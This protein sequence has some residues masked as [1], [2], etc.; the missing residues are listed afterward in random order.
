MSYHSQ[1][2]F[3]YNKHFR[4]N[5]APTSLQMCNSNLGSCA[6]GWGTSS[7]SLSGEALNLSSLNIA[8]PHGSHPLVLSLL[9][10]Y[11]HIPMLCVLLSFHCPAERSPTTMPP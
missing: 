9:Q 11:T 10:E 2:I 5:S 6:F 4:S 1:F 3:L 7:P 8:E